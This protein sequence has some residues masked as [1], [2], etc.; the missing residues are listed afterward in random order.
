MPWSEADPTAVGYIKVLHQALA[1]L[2]WREDEN[3]KIELRWSSDDDART[4][5]YTKELVDLQPDV[6]LTAGPAFVLVR[7]AT[8][9]IPIVFVRIADPVGQGFVS[10]LAHP[11]GNLTGFMLLEFSFGGKFVEMLK[12]IAPLTTRVAVLEDP[13]NSTT[14]Q[15]W[16]S[17]EGAAR[18]L[19]IEPQQKLV[20]GESEIDVVIDAIARTPNGSIIVPP[21][22]FFIVHRAHVIA[23][24]ARKRLPP[25]YWD[26]LFVRDGGLLSYGIHAADQ[27]AGAA[28][29]IDRILKGAKPGDLPVQ[30]PTKFE[31]AINL[32]T[33]KALGLTAP[34][35]LLA[36]ADE[37][38]E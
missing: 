7:E 5:A 32:K 12:T 29:Y 19:G 18:D 26:A 37:V 23:L 25:V 6:I 11:G 21:Q 13:M 9:T 34:P 33:M 16:R 22:A 20:R 28:T 31:L 17:I 14:P 24:A 2:G 1:E 36:R 3:L 35:S 27:F 4:R 38:I 15:W 8:R 10:S 30:G